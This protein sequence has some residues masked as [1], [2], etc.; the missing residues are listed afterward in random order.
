MGATGLVSQGSASPSQEFGHAERLDDIVVRTEVEE[1]HLLSF[2]GARRQNDDW[3]G[4]P[5]AYPL[6]NDG[7]IDIG[8]PEVN[9][10]QVPRS[11]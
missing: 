3:H 11:P 10:D 6:N 2:A 9:N 1:T 7:T 8:Q 4:R 5:S